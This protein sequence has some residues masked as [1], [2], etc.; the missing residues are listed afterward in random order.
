MSRA[1]PHDIEDLR[2]S[3]RSLNALWN[4]DIWII[5]TLISKNA[6]ELLKLKSFG[7]VCLDD[8]ITRLAEHGLT[9]ANTPPPTRVC[10]SC[11]TI[12][13]IKIRWDL[14]PRQAMGRSL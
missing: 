10:R 2:L 11:G 6:R 13:P 3:N 8:V 14:E 7:R 1:E 4:A 12:V 9:L 5:K